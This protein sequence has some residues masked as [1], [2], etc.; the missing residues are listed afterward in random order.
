MQK[1]LKEAIFYEIYPQS[2]YDSNG[3]GIG[4]L[5]GIIQKL[6]YVK[7]LGCNAIWLNPCYDSPFMDAGY[8]VR[9]H[10][11][12]AAR[13][14]T[15]EDLI[16]LF[17]EVHKRDMHILI[18]LVPGHTS[19][20]NPW[21]LESKK[22][23]ENPLSG[24][25]IWTNMV[26][27]APPEYR[28]MCGITDR[29]G[30]YLV[31][32]FSS[33]PALNYGFSKITHPQWQQPCDHPHCKATVEA[34]KDI[35]L[36]WL[37]KG[38][39]G[40]RVDMADSLVKN[41]D[42]KTATAK[43]WEYIMTEV[44]EKYPNSACVA[45]WCNPQMAINKGLFDMDFYLD[46][47]GNGYHNL[48]RNTDK[49]GNN[50]SYFCKD[51]NGDCLGFVKEFTK[52]LKDTQSKGY[53]SMF[54]CCHDNPRMRKTLDETAIRLAYATIFTMPGVPFLYYGD[55]IGMNYLQL[56]SK[57]GGFSRTGS[58][59]PMQWTSGKNLGF[60]TADEKDIYL[61]VDKSENAPTVE[62]QENDK[63]SML[64]FVKSLLAL[65]KANKDLGADGSFE[66]LYA[67]EGKYPFIYKR[68]KFVIAVNPSDKEVTTPLRRGGKPV[69]Q[70]GKA[71]CS[72]GTI[73]LSPQSFVAMD[74]EQ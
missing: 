57:E 7:S 52:N 31:N 39:D 44:K 65:R 66:V 18:D 11:Q 49:D 56:T 70:I 26:W 5:Q 60:S 74:I 1:W 53:I 38:C 10:K 22:P 63:D 68:G 32:Y 46:H 69:F 36:F 37:E 41:D 35:M 9:N 20:T 29:D 24:R 30:N 17:N 50:T 58:R 21:F 23:Q 2:F 62:A 33:Q 28:L 61:P 6:D 19:D 27:E 48:F 59:T 55:E 45:E 14:G 64:S 72:A 15:N 13:Y 47:D 25:Y 34:L 40:F 3:D 71:V 16:Q 73:T 51:G 8:D 43:I 4:D 42:D 54:T 67:K 12:V